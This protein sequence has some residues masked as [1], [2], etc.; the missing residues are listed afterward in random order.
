MREHKSERHPETFRK[1]PTSGDKGRSIL[2]QTSHIANNLNKYNTS[3]SVSFRKRH[4]QLAVL[5]K[6]S[7]YLVHIEVRVFEYFWGGICFHKMLPHCRFFICGFRLSLP[8]WPVVP[9][10]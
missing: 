3:S 6:D 4:K 8:P 10:L 2:V 5:R 9:T 1:Y 7:I